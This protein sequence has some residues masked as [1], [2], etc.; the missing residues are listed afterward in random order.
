MSED[1]IVVTTEAATEP[2]RDEQGRFA[3]VTTEG[4]GEGVAAGE[5]EATPE[6]EAD[7]PEGEDGDL[8]DD[9]PRGKSARTR[10]DELTRARREAE[11]ERDFYKGLVSQPTPISP[12]EGASKPASDSFETYDE[13]VDALTDWKVDQ[14]LAKTSSETATRTEGMVRQA[15][16]SSKMEAA[17]SLLPDF[18]TVV[19]SSE[20][21]VSPHVA[22]ALMDSDRGPELAYHMAQHPEVADR[23]NKL[24]PVKAAI[25]LGRLETALAAPV[26]KP[27]TKAPAPITP[28]RP[29]ATRQAD[30]SKLSGEE[31]RAER[32]K[33]GA[34][35]ANR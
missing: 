29:G 16:W 14:K 4:E 8:H 18:A 17:Q 19:G 28:I 24:S 3:P 35:W 31:Y 15:N 30:L 9:K 22:E 5:A 7:A 32:A 2:A 34:V 6:L 23:L 20:V 21:P 10:I 27:T 11:R 26:V 12:P 13:Y 33:Q 25:E 1:S